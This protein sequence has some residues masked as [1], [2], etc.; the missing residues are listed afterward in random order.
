M[1]ESERT[2]TQG[3]LCLK[4][5]KRNNILFIF[6]IHSFH[7]WQHEK[8][9]LPNVDSVAQSPRRR[10]KAEASEAKWDQPVR[11]WPDSLCRGDDG[12]TANSGF[13]ERSKVEH[14]LTCL[15]SLVSSTDTESRTLQ[16]PSIPC[17]FLSVLNGKGDAV[18]S[19]W[20]LCHIVLRVKRKTYFR[21]SLF[22]FRRCF[23]WSN[24][25]G[26]AEG[27]CTEESLLYRETWHCWK[28]VG[29]KTKTINSP[30]LNW[31]FVLCSFVF[32]KPLTI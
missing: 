31:S 16:N 4:R 28:R 15:Y 9:K 7:K 11:F 2:K 22:V 6:I 14:K 32:L 13:T 18:W 27:I 12:G 20:F 19:F 1:R 23:I 24:S 30:G 8:P 25:R 10:R 5:E 26:Y 21:F 17:I 3:S 29:F